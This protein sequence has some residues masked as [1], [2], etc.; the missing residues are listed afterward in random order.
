MTH[1]AVDV[2]EE[3]PVLAGDDRLSI[4]SVRRPYRLLTK[5]P[6]SVI[7]PG[8][9]AVEDEHRGASDWSCDGWNWE[10]FEIVTGEKARSFVEA[11]AAI[12]K[13]L[14]FFIAMTRLETV[15]SFGNSARLTA[16]RKEREF[17]HQSESKAQ[18]RKGERHPDAGERFAAE[19]R[20][21]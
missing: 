12:A 14:T 4:Q 20:N 11:I 18:Q 1:R 16:L 3:T 8:G 2:P 9:T 19:L 17:R 5:S 10:S 21:G 7:G 15:D 6:E 13:N